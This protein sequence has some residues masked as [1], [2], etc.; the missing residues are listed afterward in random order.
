MNTHLRQHL[1]KTA[2]LALPVAIGQLGH[3]MLGVT[4]S[5]MV[6][7]LG[8]VPLAAASLGNSVFVLILV[9]AI[10]LASAITPLTA[11]ARGENNHE[12]AG[13]VLRQGLLLNTLFSIL[14]ITSAFVL[15]NIL[16]LL[17]QPQDVVA[18]AIP[19]LRIMGFSFFPMMVFISFRNFIEG[20]SFTRPAMVIIL[21]A[22]LVNVAG[23]WVFIYG[24]F[25]MPA[26]GLIGAGYSSLC[27]EV[28]AA[29]AI[30]IYA[31]RSQRFTR[32]QP[33]LEY[34][35]FNIPMQKRLLRI[36]VP[37]GVQY[38]FEVGSFS[39][40]AV[41]IGWLGAKALAAHQIAIS[42]ASI[43]FMMTL[44]ISHAATIRV[45]H[46]MGKKDRRLLR[47]TGFSAIILA[48]VLMSTAALTFIVFRDFLPTLYIDDT[49][50]IPLASTLLILAAMFQLSD[51]L[52]V[53][54][55]GLLRGMTDVTVPM[56]VAIVAYWIV[57]LPLGYFF[58]F[59]VD[60]GAPGVWIG[61][62]AGLS[63]AAGA[64]LFRFHRQSKRL[65]T[66]R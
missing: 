55:H 30:V 27:V 4:D 24:N 13:I 5:L 31:F 50:V 51:G 54:G 64:F 39:F 15:S 3:V 63:T 22:N 20:L 41:M 17:D 45:G 23:N 28:F 10:G 43:S 7:H 58:G 16:P 44:G 1:R 37:S 6:G 11:I 18:Q 14:L 62:V 29:A 47:Q 48:I 26:L 42:L 61:F 21:L 34:R 8:P 40:S 2:A 12:E 25:G 52:Q 59:V 66:A 38:F 33:L 56:F 60:L 35:S 9:L 65:F 49:E 46:A 19:Y 36:G 53:V 57:G 32:Y